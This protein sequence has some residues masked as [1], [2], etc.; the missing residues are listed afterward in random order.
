MHWPGRMKNNKILPGAIKISKRFVLKKNLFSM[1]GMLY[2]WW[3]GRVALLLVFPLFFSFTPPGVPALHP[4]YVSVTEVAFNPSDKTLEISCKMFTDDFEKALVKANGQP[5]D[6]YQPRDRALAEKK[7]AAYLRKNLQFRVDG[8][9]VQMEFIGYELE[10]QSI[11][12]YF[13]VNA[14]DRSPRK[15]EVANTVLYDM[16]DKQISIVHATVNNMRKSTKVEYPVS[17]MVFNW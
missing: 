17:E 5:I 16:Y 1:V 3:G 8:R 6:L 7:I 14:I 10:E 4:F 12:V 11:F 13:Q 9:E 15:L 2:K